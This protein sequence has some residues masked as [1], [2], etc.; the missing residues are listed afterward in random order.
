M[1]D[2]TLKSAG[3]LALQVDGKNIAIQIT[4]TETFGSLID[5]LEAVGVQASFVGGKLYI[6]E[7]NGVSILANG[8]TSSIINPNANIHLAYKSSMDGFMESTSA[9]VQKTT[10]VEEKLCL[11]LIMQG[12]ILS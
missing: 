7:M 2:T 6:S 10:I 11:L 5:K 12:W 9:I 1:G 8:T 4:D 3:N